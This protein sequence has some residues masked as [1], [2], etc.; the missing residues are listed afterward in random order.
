MNWKKYE[1][2][3]LN[4]ITGLHTKKRCATCKRF[5]FD[6]Q[7]GFHDCLVDGRYKNWVYR[8]KEDKEFLTS[9]DVTI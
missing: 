8:F 7:C 6:K 4:P 5:M 9:E 2:Y 3:Y 1:N